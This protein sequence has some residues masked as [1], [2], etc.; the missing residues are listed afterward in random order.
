MELGGQDY[1]QVVQP[2]KLNNNLALNESYS[3]VRLMFNWLCI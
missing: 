2:I 1:V 3:N